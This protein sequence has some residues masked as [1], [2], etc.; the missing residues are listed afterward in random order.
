M[1]YDSKTFQEKT[2]L[3]A[4]VVII[5][6]QREGSCF[7]FLSDKLDSIFEPEFFDKM[8]VN[9]L[10]LAENREEGTR[11]NHSRFIAS[12]S[13]CIHESFAENYVDISYMRALEKCM[14]FT[15]STYKLELSNQ[16]LKAF[17]EHDHVYINFELGIVY[18]CLPDAFEAIWH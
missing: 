10:R 18:L 1:S 2:K 13:S 16:F 4:S 14:S 17:K 3:G 8:R 11:L 9:S 12:F 7:L 5:P 15:N 6:T